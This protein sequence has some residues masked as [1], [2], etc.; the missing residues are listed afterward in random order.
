MSGTIAITGATGFVGR[1]TARA[2]VAAGFAVKALVRRPELL[3]EGERELLQPVRGD[4]LDGSALAQL[5]RGADAVVHCAGE[6]ADPRHFDAVNVRGTAQLAKAARDA[7]V[8]RFVHVSSLAAREP[9]LSSYGESKH[10][11]EAVVRATLSD[12]GYILRPPAVYGPGDRATLPLIAQLTRSTAFLPGSSL[13]RFSLIHV[14]DLARALVVLVSADGPGMGMHE[15]DD[16]HRDGYSWQ[17]LA[18]I[19][20]TA[21]GKRVKVVHLPEAVLGAAA[22]ASEGWSWLSGHRP[23]LT[24]GKVAELHHRDWVC[25]HDLLDRTHDWKPAI[26][27]A[28]GFT[29]TLAWYREHGWLPAAAGAT[30][31]PARQDP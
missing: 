16:G 5:V 30:R 17:D 8:R 10:A 7:G 2:L 6:L 13:Q 28:E 11:G 19:A 26:G 14:D 18:T 29:Q 23:A 12:T 3:S 21:Q 20:G 24:R 25:R 9:G 15:L 4:L 22:F 27:F 31:T 1:R